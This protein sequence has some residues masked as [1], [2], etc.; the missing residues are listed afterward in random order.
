M[1]K[2]L[3]NQVRQIRNK[4]DNHI[5][6]KIYTDVE[7]YKQVYR[8]VWDHVAVTNPNPWSYHVLNQVYNQVYNQ[9]RKVNDHE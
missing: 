2:S 1:S 4:V 9:V 5:L 8:K 7:V 3:K 6:N